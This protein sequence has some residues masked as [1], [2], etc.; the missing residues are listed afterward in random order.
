MRKKIKGRLRTDHFSLSSSLLSVSSKDRRKW[1]ATR[2]GASR[3]EG[4]GE[5]RGGE[6]E[7][8]GKT[9]RNPKVI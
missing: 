9:K 2:R 1:S 3:G 4:G 5:G 7:E 8:E 6:R